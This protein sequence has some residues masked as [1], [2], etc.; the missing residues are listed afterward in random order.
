MLT[1][2]LRHRIQI[3]VPTHVQDSTGELQ[4][5]WAVL[6][7]YGADV[8][9]EVLTGPGRELRA[10]G[11]TLAETDARITM[12]WFP[13]LDQT[14]RILHDGKVYGITGIET[15]PTGRR[16]WRLLCQE[17]LTDGQ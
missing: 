11:T 12:R 8:P 4:T 1:H 9:S 3:E 13:G 6:P 10:S 17:G 15:D 2:R 5:T 16:E 14:M 7:L